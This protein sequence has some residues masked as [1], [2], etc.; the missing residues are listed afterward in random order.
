M[1]GIKESI[2]L[3][4]LSAVHSVHRPP[5][6]GSQDYEIMKHGTSVGSPEVHQSSRLQ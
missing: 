2:P 1:D 6:T 5:V 3:S 4:H